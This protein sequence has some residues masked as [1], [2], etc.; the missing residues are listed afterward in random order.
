MK[1]SR[2]SKGTRVA[3]KRRLVTGEINL[4]FF[5]VARYVWGSRGHELKDVKYFANIDDSI[6]Y[7]DMLKADF[8]KDVKNDPETHDMDYVTI[9][10][11]KDSNVDLM[12]NVEDGK[13]VEE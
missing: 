7:R 1:R 8:I 2:L 4:Q 3:K 13:V 10:N 9:T 6:K 12:V 11:E 5:K